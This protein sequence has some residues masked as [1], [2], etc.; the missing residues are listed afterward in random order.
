MNIPYQ[1]IMQTVEI[2]F[3]ISLAPKNLPLIKGNDGR[4]STIQWKIV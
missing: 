4:G 3:N 1:I 2:K